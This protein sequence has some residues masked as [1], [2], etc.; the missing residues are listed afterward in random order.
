L[1]AARFLFLVCACKIA[2][3]RDT[4][5]PRIG[6]LLFYKTKATNFKKIP[7]AAFLPGWRLATTI[8]RINTPQRHTAKYQYVNA[9][10]HE[11][12]L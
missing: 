7:D 3:N 2:F 4:A 11:P 8:S 6:P 5:K 12:T 10:I 1:R 9:F